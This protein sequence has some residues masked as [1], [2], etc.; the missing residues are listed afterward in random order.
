MRVAGQNGFPRGLMENPPIKAAP[1]FGFAYDV[2]GDGKTAVRGGFGLFHDRPQGQPWVD[3]SGQP[4]VAYTPSSFYGSLSNIGSGGVLAPSALVNVIGKGVLPTTMTFS[5]GLQRQ[6]W[7]STLDVSY[8]GSQSRHLIAWRNMNPIP[9][10]ARFDPKNQNPTAAAGVSLADNYLRPYQG[11][12]DITLRDFSANSNYNS[13]QVAWNRRFTRGLQYGV[14]YTW[15]RAL[16]VASG[17]SDPLSPYFSPRS[18]NYGPLAFDRQHSFVLNYMYELPRVAEKLGVSALKWVTDDWQISG[19]TSFV[20]GAPLTPGFAPGSVDYTGSSEGARLD[21]VGDPYLDPSERNFNR[22]FRT[23]AFARP[24]K[25]SFGN[26]GM[27][28]LRQPGTNNWDVSITKRFPLGAEQ[29]YL[30]FRGEMFNVWNHTQFS[31]IDG[32]LTNA[33]FGAFTAARDPRMIQ[34]SLRLSF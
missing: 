29:R 16:G 18:R 31:A 3:T 19:I 32:T 6:F 5:L 17:D 34:L 7:N 20:S 23:E 25:G 8:V 9:M 10:F 2:F 33:T 4:P 21:V 27:G 13:L 28:I 30:Q 24:V 22:N 26:A 11:Y 12:G 15:S 1:R 14:A